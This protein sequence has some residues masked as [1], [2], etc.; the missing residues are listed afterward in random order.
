VAIAGN[1]FWMG[2][3]HNLL[4]EKST[5]IVFGANALDRNPAYNY[6]K[7]AEFK[8]AVVFRDCRDC[9]VT[10]LHVQGVHHVDASMVLENCDRMNVTG[11]T[12]LDNDGIALLLNNVTRSRVTQ[13]LIFDDR[14]DTKSLALK[15]V[16]C[17]DTAITDNTFGRPVEI[18]DAGGKID[19]NLEIR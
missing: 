12:L 14:P 15:A 5:A 7:T 10:G 18:D 4:I 6:G 2:F 11:C 9:T 17:R 8:N 3:D 19:E 13:C 16:G 1:T